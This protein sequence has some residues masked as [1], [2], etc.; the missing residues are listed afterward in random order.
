MG[1]NDQAA[2]V[3][4][5]DGQSGASLGTVS[6]PLDNGMIAWQGKSVLRREVS[7][8]LGT[9]APQQNAPGGPGGA[10]T[11]PVSPESRN[12]EA[13]GGEGPN[14]VET[15][16]DDGA[17]RR[18]RVWGGFGIG[19]RMLNWPENGEELEADTGVFPA[20]ELG[21]TVDIAPSDSLAIGVQLA[22]QSSVGSEISET[23]MDAPPETI[24]VRAHHFE[25]LLALTIGH[26]DGF[27]VAPALG[28]GTRN[29][30][31]EVHHLLTPSYSLAGPLAH[32]GIRIPFGDSVALRLVPEAQLVLVVGEQL[33]ERGV[34]SSGISIGGDIALEI[35]L[36]EAF[37]LELGFREA[38]ALLSSTQ[39]G[40][41]TSDVERFITMRLV[42]RP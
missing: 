10:T 8:R 13:Y 27:Y 32:L 3:D 6:V 40:G 30:R 35:S 36:S 4:F 16:T 25:G 17:E 11:A 19:M 12:P 5:R 37:A 18:A 22:Y 14:A 2:Q 21:T 24:G 41:S 23:H 42:G 39:D 26:A 28:Y 34:K 38:H 15:E 7:A 20:Y 9:S 29:L 31:P 33:A 1:A